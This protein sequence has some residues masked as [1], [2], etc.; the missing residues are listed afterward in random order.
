VGWFAHEIDDPAISYEGQWAA[1]TKTYRSTHRQYRY[2]DD[3]TARLSFRFLGAGLR[4]K[5]VAFYT[6]GIF[7]VRIDGKVVA[8][9]DAYYPEQRDRYGNF[10]STD[11]FKLAHGWHLLEV[12]T[13]HRQNPVSHGTTIAMDGIEVYQYGFEPTETP[14]A[15]VLLTTPTFT[16][17][18]FP[19][20]SELVMA[21]PTVQATATIV[22]PKVISVALNIAYD[23][24]GNQSADPAE[25]VQGVSVRLITVGTN[26][27]LASGYTNDEGFIRLEA[28]TN[29]KV[30]LVVPYLSKYWEVPNRSSD[31]RFSLIIPPTN[32]PGLIP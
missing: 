28:M 17:S 19:V 23:T 20:K 26:Q 21:P 9:I 12:I 32:Q 1:Y 7:E 6:F 22:P 24:N 15:T 2:S 3:P 8:T 5:Y 16:P 31:L 27:I 25:G 13:L 4:L 29:D 11:V 14:T 10:L 18:P 30:R